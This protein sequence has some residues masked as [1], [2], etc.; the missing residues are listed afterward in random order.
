MK[1]NP[2]LAQALNAHAI[3]LIKDFAPKDRESLLDATKDVKTPLAIYEGELLTIENGE[4]VFLESVTVSK[5]YAT[6]PVD[7]GTIKTYC[8]L[9]AASMQAPEIASRINWEDFFPQVHA[10]VC[11]GHITTCTIGKIYIHFPELGIAIPHT[12]Q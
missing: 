3:S 8:I 2:L 9:L 7:P 6:K 10:L 4:L 5:N 1:I 12:A 11:R